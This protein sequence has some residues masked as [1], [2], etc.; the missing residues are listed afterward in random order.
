MKP[1]ED[2]KFRIWTKVQNRWKVLPKLYE[3]EALAKAAIL[4]IAEQMFKDPET[5]TKFI[6]LCEVEAF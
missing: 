6:S 1:E 5:Q 3:S 4:R 2:V